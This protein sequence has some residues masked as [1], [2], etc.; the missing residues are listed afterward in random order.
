M[1]APRWSGRNEPPTPHSLSPAVHRRDNFFTIARRPKHN[2]VHRP[3]IRHCSCDHT[4][5][6]HHCWRGA[7]R[8]RRGGRRTPEGFR[9]HSPRRP[10]TTDRQALRRRLSASRTGRAAAIGHSASARQRLCLSRNSVRKR[11]KLRARGIF[12]RRRIFS[13]PHETAPDAG[14]TGGRGR[15]GISMGRASEPH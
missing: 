14:G 13:A 10:E 8:D 5:R 3:G 4:E 9:G 7:G 11:N 1:R 6:C 12:E 15:R 2:F